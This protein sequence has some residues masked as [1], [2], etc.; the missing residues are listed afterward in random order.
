[1]FEDQTHLRR[2]AE[3]AQ[4]FERLVGIGEMSLAQSGGVVR[5]PIL[6]ADRQ[7]KPIR[8]VI[9]QGS[10]SGRDQPP[11]RP[12][13]KIAH[14]FVDWHNAPY[15]NGSATLR[16]V[17][18]QDFKLR[19]ND[20]QI[21]SAVKIALHF[22]VEENALPLPKDFALFQINGIEPFAANHSACVSGRKV[23]DIGTLPSPG[24]AAGQH[25]P[26]DSRGLAGNEI[27]DAGYV[28]AV[29]V[30]ERS[31][32]K[33]VFDGADPSSGKNL[34]SRWTHTLQVFHFR[35]GGEVCGCHSV[36]AFPIIAAM[37]SCA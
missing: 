19:L 28:G 2:R 11:D 12:R 16:F 4:A 17:L 8:Q 21:A 26:K 15:L 25:L 14:A 18:R 23:V 29:F 3:I 24:K 27:P 7:G 34:S 1:L 32:V 10:K 31:I 33:E 22:P 6:L 37:R 30:A 35:G 36:P 5:E 9:P 13:A 20:L